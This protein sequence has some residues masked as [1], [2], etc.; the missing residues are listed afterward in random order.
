M[1]C[2]NTTPH[3]LPVWSV[4]RSGMFARRRAPSSRRL[5]AFSNTASAVSCLPDRQCARAPP[6]SFI[7]SYCHLTQIQYATIDCVEMQSGSPQRR[8]KQSKF[9]QT[10]PPGLQPAA[11]RLPKRNKCIYTCGEKK[12]D[13]GH[14]Y[15]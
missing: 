7:G 15:C 2:M 3:S 8:S 10:P 13:C 11:Q 6:Q 9:N 14:S 4:W 1:V 5:I 12:G